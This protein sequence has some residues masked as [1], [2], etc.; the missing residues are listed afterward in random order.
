MNLTKK[1]KS[2]IFYNRK[3]WLNKYLE[4]EEALLLMIEKL[5]K[6][7]VPSEDAPKVLVKGQW[8]PI[9]TPLT[10]RMKKFFAKYKYLNDVN[11]EQF[12]TD[13]FNADYLKCKKE[14]FDYY[15]EWADMMMD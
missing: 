14:F 15:F 13:R 9:E 7:F 1:G 2:N 12:D 5:K 11:G 10:Q 8:K 6:D 4:Y 3:L